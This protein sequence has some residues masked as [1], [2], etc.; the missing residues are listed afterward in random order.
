[1]RS[2]FE[3][4]RQSFFVPRPVGPLARYRYVRLRWRVLFAAV[5]AIGWAIVWTLSKLVRRN[6]VDR[7]P[8]SVL[9]VQ[10]DHLGDAIL[11]TGL[12]RGLK[13]A[14]P[15]ARIDVLASQAN[16]ELFA[17]AKEIDGVFVARVTR[18]DSGGWL[19]WIV[20]MVRW[21]WCLRRR[22]YDLAIDPR[23]D[24]PAAVIL[25]LCGAPIRL[26]WG[27][28]GGGFLLT[29]Q[30]EFVW[31]RHEVLSRQALLDVLGIAAPDG[32]IAWPPQ[33]VPSHA[34]REAIAARLPAASATVVLHV[35]AGTAA[36][37]WPMDHWHELIYRL[38]VELAPQIV[39][40]GSAADDRHFDA[41]PGVLN[42]CG[43]LSVD[44]LSAL[45]E[46]AD[47][48]IGGDSGPAHLAAAVGTPVVALFSG[49]NRAEQW[50]PW[51]EYSRVIKRSTLCS[52]C[53]RHRCPLADHP[54]V[55]GILP[56]A[57]F[58]AAHPWLESSHQAKSLVLERTV[59]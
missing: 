21:G 56:A 43:Q 47:L 36:K 20:S 37:R 8:H 31:G 29:H 7:P 52:P 3:A 51:G 38:N 33:V 9:M 32:E 16:A 23:G 2:W 26:G 1:M 39:L 28:G 30:A 27:C 12:L 48:L 40:V 19:G 53:H 34:A 35:G 45:V 14:Y 13:S 50:R 25:A 5:D 57:V 46:Q 59:A 17:C 4:R 42:W 22:G 55:R 58:A 6:R 18:F 54:C 44:E 49:T 41:I 11:S 24:F 10:L 15:E